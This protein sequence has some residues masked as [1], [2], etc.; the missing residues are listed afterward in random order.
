ML[1]SV[2]V[3][4]LLT[5]VMVVCGR[6]AASRDPV[7]VGGTG[8]YAKNDRFLQPEIV[9]IIVAFTFVFGCR[10]G[11]GVDFFHYL[12][13]YVDATDGRFEFFFL[14]ISSALRK[15]GFGYPV[16]FSVWAFLQIAL[17]YYAFRHQRFLFPLLAFFLIIGYGYMSWMNIIRQEIASGIFLVSLKYLDE[18]KFWKYMLC[19]V[20]ACGFHKAAVILVIFYPIFLWRKDLFVKLSWQLLIYVVALIISFR[21]STWF[22]ELLEKPFRL[23]ADWFGYKN[24]LYRF[25]QVDSLNSR[26]RFQANTGYGFYIGVFRTLPIILLSRQLK[27]YYNSSLFNI[28]YSLWFIRIISA[29]LVGGSIILNRPFAF[30]TNYRMIMYAYFVFYCMKSKRPM[31]QLFGGAYMLLFVLLFLHIISN[32]ELNTAQFVFFWQR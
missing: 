20:L 12:N 26:D 3:Y 8:L 23:F 16:Y 28:I 29:L 1:E 17:F 18:R 21:F 14:T 10:Y 9:A 11:V 25:L 30:F 6:I 22:V 7:Y 13:A 24:Y 32:G 19:V 4:G 15:L 5:L 31:L 2:F 27:E